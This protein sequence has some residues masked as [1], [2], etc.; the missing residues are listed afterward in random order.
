[1]TYGLND[2][3]NELLGFVDLLLRIGHDQAV[4]VLLLVASMGGIRA[5]LSFL[6]G[7]LSTNSDLSLRFS[8]HLLQ[9][10]STRANK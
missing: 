1:M 3:V 10:V 2:V 8:L 7:A 4:Q 9:G 5:T 6:N